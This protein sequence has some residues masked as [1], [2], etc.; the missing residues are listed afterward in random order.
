MGKQV[1]SVKNI[2]GYGHLI[3]LYNIRSM[4]LLPLYNDSLDGMRFK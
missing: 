2:V 1:I 3:S 4:F